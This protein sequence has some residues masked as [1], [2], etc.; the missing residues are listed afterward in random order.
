MTLIIVPHLHMTKY[1]A[2]LS[3]ATSPGRWAWFVPAQNILASKYFLTMPQ[4]P[5]ETGKSSS[6]VSCLIVWIRCLRMG[7]SLDAIEACW[8]LL[9]VCLNFWGC[10]PCS[11]LNLPWWWDRYASL[12]HKIDPASPLRLTRISRGCGSISNFSVLSCTR[13]PI[14]IC[15]AMHAR[16]QN[17]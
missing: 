11:E 8:I 9:E 12:L 3:K 14:K 4:C 13:V 10:A 16:D 17:T 7:I 2:Y 6:L 15:E 1:S 5:W